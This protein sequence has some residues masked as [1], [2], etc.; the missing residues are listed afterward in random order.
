MATKVT[1]S[2]STTKAVEAARV[3][4]STS[5]PSAVTKARPTKSISTF[6]TSSDAA[7]VSVEEFARTITREHTEAM[8]LA[9]RLS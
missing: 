6:K 7:P 9:K 4:R 5:A 3:K 8:E 1:K 2:S